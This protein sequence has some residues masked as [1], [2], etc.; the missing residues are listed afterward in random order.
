MV[1]A[2]DPVYTEESAV[3]F[4]G[5]WRAL[6][7]PEGYVALELRKAEVTRLM[8]EGFAQAG[9]RTRVLGRAPGIAG[10]VVVLECR[11]A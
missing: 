1:V 7:P 4:A 3:N 6:Q 8:S 10:E 11:P 5:A 2:S 9:Y